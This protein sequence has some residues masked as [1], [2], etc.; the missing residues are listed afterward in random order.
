MN[1]RK[2][3]KV[4]L[5]LDLHNYQLRW[6]EEAPKKLVIAC[7]RPKKFRLVTKQRG[8]ED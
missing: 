1:K 6:I 8:D 7:G 2:F 5:G 4:V 3:I